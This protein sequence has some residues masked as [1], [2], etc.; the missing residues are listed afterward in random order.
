VVALVVLEVADRDGGAG[1]MVVGATV[2][3][4]LVGGVVPMEVC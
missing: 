1:A 4:A 3:V 2:S